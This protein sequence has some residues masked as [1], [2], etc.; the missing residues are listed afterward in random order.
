MQSGTDIRLAPGAHVVQFYED[1]DALASS[2]VRYLSPAVTDGCGVIVIA[3]PEHQEAFR[4]GLGQA[5]LPVDS[6]ELEGQVLLLDAAATLAQFV[7]D[8]RIDA[9]AFEA[10]VGALVRRTASRGRPVCAYGEMVS[11]LWDA[12]DVVAAIE[13]ERLWDALLD[14]VPFSL[15]CAYPSRMMEPS[16]AFAAFVEVCD[17]HSEVV[18][19]APV[20]ADAEITRRFPRTALAPGHARRFV[21][22]VLTGWDCPE[23]VDEGML[24]V[25]EL[26][27]NAL[28]HARSGFTVSLAR[29]D[30]VVRIAVGDVATGPPR[31]RPC[32]STSSTG[33]GLPLVAGFA[34]CWG[35]GLQPGGKVVWADLAA[36]HASPPHR[37]RGEHSR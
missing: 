21:A 16:N 3:T 10:S 11:L 5:G 14:E 26:A 15:F 20:L 4:C 6:A 17:V 32:N 18:A 37:T 9:E 8:G 7:L 24:V 35:H 36:G 33:R 1:D 2:V 25:S 30:G 19:G 34:A 12:G 31:P 27:T 22:E 23:L 28:A 29:V 13:L